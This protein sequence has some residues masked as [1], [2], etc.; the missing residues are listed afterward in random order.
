MKNPV[1]QIQ[2][3]TRTLL[4]P[5]RQ[6][7]RM[8]RHKPGTAPGTLT[9]TGEEREEPVTLTLI[10]YKED[11]FDEVHGVGSDWRQRVPSSELMS[12]L[13]V[14]GVHDVP[15][16]QEIG[17]HLGIHP[18]IMEDIIHPHQRPKFEPFEDQIYIVVRMLHIRED[19]TVQ[20]EQISIVLGKNWIVSFQQFPG[21]VFDAV[22]ERLRSGKGL[23]RKMGPDYL[24]YALID[25][26]VDYYFVLL[27][28]IG[29]EVQD[30][31][32][33]VMDNPTKE[34]IHTI[35]ATKQTIIS[36]RKDIWPV[37]EL[38][39]AMIRDE[40]GLIK[41]RT[42]TYLRDVYDH[43]IQVIDLMET[44]RD[45]LSGLTDLYLSSLSQRMNE[46]M[47]FLTI[48]G[49]IFIPLTFIAG[50]YGMNFA[51]MPELG[52]E[53]GYPAVW[54]IMIVTGAG[55]FLYFRHKKWL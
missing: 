11:H 41:K 2:R 35:R 4:R 42:T 46:V 6:I 50:V 22:R 17:E 12:W 52:W 36:Y 45:Q 54:A 8:L 20:D 23:I 53:F 19:G 28:R 5:A 48:I 30:I 33:A 24:A 10:D 27:E 9:Y 44:Y 29:S 32:M 14:S 31:E 49:S 47:Q 39:S 15:I 40:S 38:L 43:A 13:D 25:L 34:T 18:L 26:I 7:P 21:D 3:F 55:L 51:N 16:I 37:R 1:R